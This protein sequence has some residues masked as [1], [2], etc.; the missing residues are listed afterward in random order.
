MGLF[1]RGWGGK[2]KS[3]ARV[4]VCKEE[5]KGNREP[6]R[7]LGSFENVLNF[8]YLENCISGEVYFTL[9]NKEL[10]FLMSGANDVSK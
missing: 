8:T 5:N 6:I 9:I 10:V 2:L 4:P 3:L 1:A 7:G